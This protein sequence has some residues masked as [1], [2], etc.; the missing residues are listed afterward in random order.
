MKLRTD[1]DALLTPDQVTKFHQGITLRFRLMQHLDRELVLTPDEKDQD[2]P[3]S[4]RTMPP[5]PMA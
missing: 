3:D 1:A 5:R 4:G 2:R